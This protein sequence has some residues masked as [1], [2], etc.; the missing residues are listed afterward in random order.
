MA[1]TQWQEKYLLEEEIEIFLEKV[2]VFV[3]NCCDCGYHIFKSFWDAPIGSVL[4]AKHEGDSQSL[5]HD[6]YAV[7]LINSESVTV[8][9]LP[10]FMSKPAHV[11]VKHAG[12]IRCEITGTKRYSSDLEQGGLEIHVSEFRRRNN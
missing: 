10:K 8:G 11:F 12:K 4:S 9:H 6:K 3:V 1:L 7:A 5:V 2:F